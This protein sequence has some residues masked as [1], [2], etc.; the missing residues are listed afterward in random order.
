M[1]DLACC[2]NI[3]KG[4][5]L[6]HGIGTVL[7]TNI[8]IGDN[9]TVLHNVTIGAGKSGVPRIGNNVYIGAGAIIIGGV[10]I[11]DN[12]KIG[13]GAIVVKNIPSNTTVVS[14]KPRIILH[15]C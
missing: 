11:G 4:F 5:V 10:S 7:N 2:K 8:S 9:C 12:V 6:M 13:A 15:E 1:C 3:G 14:E